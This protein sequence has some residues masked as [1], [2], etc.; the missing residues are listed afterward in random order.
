MGMLDIRNITTRLTMALAIAAG[1][2]LTCGEALG[3]TPVDQ[4]VEDVDPL[5]TSQ[6]YIERGNAQFTPRSAV[7]DRLNR[8]GIPSTD[9]TFFRYEF[10]G[11]G[12]RALMPHANYYV[13]SGPLKENKKFNQQP[14]VDGA[15]QEVV[16]AGVVYNLV[17]RP[18]DLPRVL[19]TKDD[20]ENE[21]WFA[22][23][24]RIDGR[25]S[26]RAFGDT[27]ANPN[28][29]AGWTSRAPRMSPG[30]SRD[31][32]HAMLLAHL[33]RPATAYHFDSAGATDSPR[34]HADDETTAK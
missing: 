15:Y 8:H 14:I 3:Q 26:A 16:P 11:P 33:S 23:D 7:F 20:L 29:T 28:V 4:T 24:Q 9:E 32:I 25:L 21:R 18:T 13:S 2:A 27:A 6:R 31:P 5:G 19:R 1:F 10:R 22:P 12:V 17:P 34:T 30:S